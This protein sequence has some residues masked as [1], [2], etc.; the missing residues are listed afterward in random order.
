[1]TYLQTTLTANSF[2]AIVSVINFLSYFIPTVLVSPF[3]V[4]LIVACSSV[5][6]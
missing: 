1:L 4:R 6:M 2:I 3:T 5:R